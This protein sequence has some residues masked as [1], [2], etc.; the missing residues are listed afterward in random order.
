MFDRRGEPDA[1]EIIVR[2]ELLAIYDRAFD[3]QF[4]WG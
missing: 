2:G 4:G 3:A 1:Q